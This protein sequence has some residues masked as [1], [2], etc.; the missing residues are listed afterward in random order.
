MIKTLLVL[1]NSFLSVPSGDHRFCQI[2]LNISV[3]ENYKVCLNKET[4]KLVS[5]FSGDV[6]H[7]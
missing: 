5:T 4:I 1:N 7:I 6:V 2:F 3:F